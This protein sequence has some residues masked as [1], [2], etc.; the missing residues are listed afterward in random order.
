MKAKKLVLLILDGWGYGKKDQSDAAYQANTPFFDSLLQTYPN[1][2][3]EAS[4]EAVG[5]P[6]G[7]MGN[8]EVGHMNL[9]AGRIV[10]QEL[11]RINKAISDRTLHSNEVLVNAFNYAKQNQKA[12][13]L[14]G[15]VSDGGVHAHINHLKALCDAAHGQGLKDVFIHGFLD[16]RD[17]DPNAGLGY[18][19]SLEDHLKASTGK[20]ASLIGRYYA[21]DRDNRWERVK[22]AYDLMVKGIG[23]KATNAE[24]AIQISYDAGV[25]DEFVKPIVITDGHGNPTATIR[26]DDVVICFNYRTDRGREITTAL[27]QADFPDF[28]MKKL[29]LHY[30]TMTTYD[31]SFEGVKVIF[32]KDDLSNTL[33]EV[34]AAN[35]KNQIRIAE[36]EKYP[37]VTFFFSGGRE[38]EFENEKRILVPSPK[39]ATYDLQPEMSAAGITES[40]TKELASEWPD[41]V[42][43]NFANPDMVG[44]TG[45][46]SAVVKAVETADYCAAQVV[47]TG[48]E[49]GYSFIILA[50][51]GNSEFMINADGSVN[52][53][54]TTN[55]VPCILID[56]DI[57][58][59]ADGKLG[60]IAPTVLKIMGIEIP[61]IMTGNCLV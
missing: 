7:Q 8:S 19:K 10:Y 17:T 26:P 48:V 27:S 57:K 45:V 39:V 1:S 47:K 16:G 37:H 58:Q 25:T 11:G 61:A 56:S 29:P 35:H 32:T 60:D 24:E 40:I 3:L 49:H 18:I 44:H 55:L 22:L 42:C 21:M 43:L 9:G 36:T 30:V 34:L 33:G 51:H 4:G 28:D 6:A 50:D 13:H 2:K 46:F 20:I 15:L 31:E 59:I 52:T 54:H 5:L 23:L 53:A 38:K 14:I 12:V 41:F